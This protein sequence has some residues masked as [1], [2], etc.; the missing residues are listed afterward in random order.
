MD[1]LRLDGNAAAGTLGEVFSF[2]VTTTHYACEGCGRVA[3][4]GEAIAYM[5]EI[6]TIVRCP[7]C[8]DALIRLAHNRGRYWI[9]L[10]GIRY[11]QVEDV[12]E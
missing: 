3:H 11:L 6:G 1:E 9:D 12:A 2:E 8:E 10:R 7:S 5:T 4:I